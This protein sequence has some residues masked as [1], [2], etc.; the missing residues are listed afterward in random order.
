[1]YKAMNKTG[2]DRGSVL[3][4]ALVIL[5]LITLMGIS[6]TT[7]SDIDVQIA[8]NEREFVQE[9]YV[10][11]SAWREAIEWLDVR[12]QAP[13]LVNKDLFIGGDTGEH[14]L[15]VR[16]YGDGGNGTTNAGFDPATRDGFLGTGAGTVNYWYKIAYLNAD[17]AMTGVVA[18]KFGEGFRQYS[19]IVSSVANG[20]Q[21]VDVT[22]T[23]IL[24]TG[25]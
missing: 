13:A 6:V 17:T 12:A 9:F 14:A 15:N 1:M 21:R 11:D 20:R 23:K 22:V 8:K 5:V 7:T 4:I 19:F 16:N 10:A 18:P 2:N 24:P 25:E 3:V